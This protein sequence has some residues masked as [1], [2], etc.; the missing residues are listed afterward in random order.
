MATFEITP[1]SSFS[2]TSLRSSR[3]DQEY[4]RRRK[5]ARSDGG[6]R[7]MA[8][9]LVWLRSISGKMTVTPRRRQKTKVIR[10][11]TT[12]EAGNVYRQNVGP[13]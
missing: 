4:T 7:S 8:V 1:T 5:R 3:S 6:A 11:W 13:E 12:C 2:T 9:S 10:I